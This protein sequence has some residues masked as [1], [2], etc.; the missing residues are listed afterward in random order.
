VTSQG[1]SQPITVTL[2]RGNNKAGAF[3]AA[4]FGASFAYAGYTGIQA[5]YLVLGIVFGVIGLLLLALA[6][7][8]YRT[9]STRL[10]Q[11]IFDAEGFRFQ[12]QDGSWSVQWAELSGV[13]VH[14][15]YRT[16][17]E[18]PTVF[19]YLDFWLSPSAAKRADLEYLR[20]EDRYRQLLMGGQKGPEVEQA[21]AVFGRDLWRD[22]VPE[23]A[24]TT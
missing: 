12:T 1:D 23:G 6:V 22:D 4:L 7:S 9:P 11:L 8:A 24:P 20:H 21:V 13:T 15:V 19:E 14:R 10:H 18:T 17:R 3:V 5:H 16:D 2:Y